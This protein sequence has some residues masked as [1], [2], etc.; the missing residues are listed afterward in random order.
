LDRLFEPIA[1]VVAIGIVAIG[2]LIGALAMQRFAR[3][4]ITVSPGE[5]AEESGHVI[6]GFNGTRTGRVSVRGEQWQAET[7]APCELAP[8]NRIR[9]LSRVGLTLRVSPLD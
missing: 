1:L 7:D 4:H 6:G 8:G 2:D 9:V 3:P 5:T